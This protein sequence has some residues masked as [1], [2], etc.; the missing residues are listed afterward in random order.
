MTNNP[1]HTASFTDTYS[2]T[3]TTVQTRVVPHIITQ[4][5]QIAHYF[6]QDLEEFVR[7]SHTD[8]AK[9]LQIPLEYSQDTQDIILML[10]EDV[11]HMLRDQLITCVHMLLS[12]TEPDPNTG[13]YPLRWH[14]RYTINPDNTPAQ[15]SA[16]QPTDPL[17]P[18]TQIGKALSPPRNV[19]VG[20]R[21]ALL[22]DWN[23]SARDRRH[24]VRRP[25]YCFDWVP[26]E[27]RFDPTNLVR[28]GE[29]GM[30]FDSARIEGEAVTRHEM[31]TPAYRNKQP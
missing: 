14:A 20:A 26:E 28:Y 31:T 3:N 6:T 7:L 8:L 22:I 9:V 21:F 18:Y 15:N 25:T 19:W 30:T 11:A 4:S 29:G 1:K 5:D 2:Y 17:A 10:Y 23:P 12:E 16:F 24:N 27:A 13:Y